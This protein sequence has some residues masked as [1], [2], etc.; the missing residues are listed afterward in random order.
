MLLHGR[1]GCYGLPIG[2]N[3]TPFSH[4]IISSH[5]HYLHYVT[6]HYLVISPHNLTPCSHSSTCFL[7][8]MYPITISL[9]INIPSQ[10]NLFPHLL[11]PSSQPTLSTHP[12]NPP[13]Q[14]ILFL[15]FVSPI[16]PQTFACMCH[17]IYP[18]DSRNKR[19]ILPSSHCEIGSSKAGIC[20][21]ERWVVE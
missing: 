15:S 7:L 9:Y 17:Q 20:Y 3:L 5:T 10:H 6:T 12:V 11:S 21:I 4:P 1:Y 18:S 16:S 19:R 14:P 13:S 8:I 2:N